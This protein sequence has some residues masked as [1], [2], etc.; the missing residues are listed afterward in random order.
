MMGQLEIDPLVL[1]PPNPCI[2]SA[3][4]CADDVAREGLRAH[5]IL[6]VQL[7]PQPC[8][9]GRIGPLY[10]AYIPD[11]SVMHGITRLLLR[12][13]EGISLAEKCRL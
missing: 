7:N 13:V 6:G 3:G 1:M 4:E 5:R 2:G 12:D 9:D 8:G 11:R 10:W